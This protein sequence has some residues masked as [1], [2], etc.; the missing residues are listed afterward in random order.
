MNIIKNL[1]HN[2][3][4]DQWLND[5]LVVYIKR[6]VFTY[7]DNEAIMQRFKNMKTRRGQL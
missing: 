1:L 7:I 6:D 4:R 2:R 3:M 5:S